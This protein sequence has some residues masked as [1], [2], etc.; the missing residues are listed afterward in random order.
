[1]IAQKTDKP[2]VSK[3]AR[4]S[5]AP[6]MDWTGIAIYFRLIK[7]LAIVSC[8]CWSY[9]WSEFGLNPVAVHLQVAEGRDVI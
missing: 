8:E 7:E 5:V 3:A 4:L 2:L 1:M 9:C 6:M